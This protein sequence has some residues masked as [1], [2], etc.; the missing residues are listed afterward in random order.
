M[1]VACIGRSEIMYDSMLAAEKAGFEIG[2]VLTAQE[3]PEYTKRAEDFEKFASDRSIPFIKTAK[4]NTPDVLNRIK[5]LDGLD[6][7][8]SVNYSG[9]LGAEVIEN[10][11][12]GVLNAHG[13]DL[14]RYRGNACQAWAIINGENRVGLCI[15]K[16]KA[17]ELDSGDIIERAYFSLSRSTYI[18]DIYRWMGSKI[19]ELFVLAALKLA[20]EP[21][22]VLETQSKD[23]TKALRCYPRSPSDGRIRFRDSAESVCRLVRASAEP[24]AG[25]FCELNGHELRVWRTSVVED[26]E[27]FCAIPGQ[28]TKIDKLKGVIQ[29]ATGEG[30]LEIS[31][32]QL[33]NKRGN[34]TQFISSSRTR[35]C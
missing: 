3:A 29:V 15:H 22:F 8:L 6:L 17:D 23:P 19:P 28:V 25:A 27:L 12:L 4:I 14:P 2:L 9:V 30:K 20:K 5:S 32:V 16:M 34:P 11:P 35:L 26:P 7:A 31:E 1:K 21:G 13:G 10:F 18:G 24:F 33:G